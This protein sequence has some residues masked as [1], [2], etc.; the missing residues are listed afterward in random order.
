MICKI[1]GD[2]FSVPRQFH[3]LLKPLKRYIC[4]T[5]LNNLELDLLE[6]V[7]PL[8]K[9]Y[10][11]K[12]LHLYQNL[13]LKKIDYLVFEYSVIL[14]RLL[15]KEGSVLLADKFNLKEIDIYNMLAKIL[16]SD[17]YLVSFL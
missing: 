14:G 8:D 11:L 12:V 13:D 15:L 16:E 1:C 17:I 9:G 10:T 6:E 5:C 2:F 4:P 3:E 7:I